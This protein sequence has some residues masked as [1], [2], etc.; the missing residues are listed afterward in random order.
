MLAQCNIRLHKISS[1]CPTITN[2]FPSEDLAVDM[3]GLDLGQTTP[4]MQR[5]LGLGWD[6]S[7]D[8]FKFQITIN[9]K[10][11]T[12]RG[13]LSVVNSVYD[14]LG[15]AVPVI[16]EGRVILRGSSTDICE[17]DTELPK[18]KLQ[19]WQQW[20][21][22]LKHLQ[23][24]IPRM[25]TSIPLSAAVTKEIHVFYD[26]STKAVGAVGYLKL[27]DRDGHNEVGF[28]SQQRWLG[29]NTPQQIT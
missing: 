13:V 5:S 17:W 1:N 7:R 8:L 26:A 12:K 18:D 2:T 21:H 27:T 22:S 15:F 16:V 25:F 24:E 9:D 23:L 28:L 14:P 20:K 11:F 29:R 3:Q 19:Q 4:P 6:L 10:P